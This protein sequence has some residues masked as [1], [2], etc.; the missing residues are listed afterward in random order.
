MP[1]RRAR[2]SFGVAAELRRTPAL[3]R[4]D[5]ASQVALAERL[6]A[7]QPYA[8]AIFV[9][10]PDGRVLHD[11]DYPAT[12]D[13]SLADREYFQAHRDDPSLER[14]IGRPLRSRSALGWFLAVTR[15]IGED[16]FRGVAVAAL[17]PEYFELLYTR[18]GL[19]TADSV[20]LFHRD[21]TLI[22][23]HPH[24]ESEIGQSFASFAIFKKHLPSAAAGSYIT[25]SGVYSYERLVSYR[26]LDEM[27][28]VVAMGQSTQGILGT[29]RETA[30]GAALGL[31]ALA[32]LLAALLWLFIRQQRSREL[33]RERRMQSDK[34]EALGYLTG[35]V[36]HDFANLLHV[37][38]ATLRVVQAAPDPQ[39]VR[40][41]VAVAE[42]AVL[43]G[44]Q[45]VDQLR[46]FARRQPLHVQPTDLNLL[47]TAGIEL[48]RQATGPNLRLGTDLGAGV[49]R[50]LLDETELEVALVNLLVNARDAGAGSV[51][52]K[53]CNDPKSPSCVCLS[54][55]DD[56]S[57]MSAEARRRVFEPY[58]STKGTQ[59]TGLGLAQVYGL[60]RQIGGDVHIDSQPGG[61]TVTL[62]FLKAPAAEAPV[63][64]GQAA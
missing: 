28:L 59:G 32:L 55:T 8:R 33:A 54:V 4:H 37:V 63:G 7:L 50:C 13:V 46:A 10:G 48:L 64:Q 14:Y 56:G 11:T 22:A 12:P 25:R 36:S 30:L 1:T 60:M 19:G 49:A 35:G 26:A 24:R 6:Q 38:S 61:T 27:P 39:R 17:L 15:R 62:I 20:M 52:L 44:S 43:R 31:G 42:R 9:V 5:A 2:S 29:W 57:G 3:A 23:R 53:T 40:E 47:I 21:G 34:L 45:L 58:F 16:E 41:A 18:L 51:I